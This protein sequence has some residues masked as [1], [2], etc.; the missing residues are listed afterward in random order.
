MGRVH[1]ALAVGTLDRCLRE[2][3]V[4]CEPIVE[5]LLEEVRV[6]GVIHADETPWHQGILGR[7]LW[8][9]LS[10]TTAVFHIGSRRHEEIRDLLGDAILGWLVTDGYGAY[11]DYA[12]RQRCP[13]P[14]G[15]RPGCPSRRHPLRRVAGPRTARPDQGR[16]RGQGPYHPQPDPG[17]PETGLQAPPRSRD[18]ENPRPRP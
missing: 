17:P 4:A 13:D 12:R 18:R 16:R 3:G 11:R 7:W 15:D 1:V 14:Q 9:V 8:V 5:D 2:V 6:A 10:A